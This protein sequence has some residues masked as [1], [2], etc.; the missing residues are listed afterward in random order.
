[1][2]QWRVLQNLSLTTFFVAKS[3][4]VGLSGVCYKISLLQMSGYSKM[5]GYGLSGVCYKISLLPI[6]RMCSYR[7]YSLS[8]VCYKISLLHTITSTASASIVSVAC[9]TKSLSYL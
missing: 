3:F 4:I 5:C 8:G 1:M 7:G 9:A 2:S 6:N